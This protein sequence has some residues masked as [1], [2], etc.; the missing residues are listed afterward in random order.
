MKKKPFTERWEYR[1]SI[2][3][4]PFSSRADAERYLTMR[5]EG[6]FP[7]KARLVRVLTYRIEYVYAWR[8][9]PYSGLW[10]CLADSDGPA[11]WGNASRRAIF[12]DP[13]CGR[14]RRKAKHAALTAKP[15]CVLADARGA[16][17]CLVR[18]R[19]RVVEPT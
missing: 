17:V 11:G 19:R 18:I 2:F 13:D 7:N 14:S 16:D 15:H 5:S 10:W 4:H 6:G 12:G 1:S 9:T 8:R 3:V